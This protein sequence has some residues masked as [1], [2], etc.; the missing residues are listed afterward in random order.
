MS[1]TK[2]SRRK[3]YLNTIC[4]VLFKLDLLLLCGLMALLDTSRDPIHSIN[5]RHFLKMPRITLQLCFHSHH[6]TRFSDTNKP[7]PDRIPQLS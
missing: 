5:T 7:F 3:R 4:I 2:E 6:K 1:K